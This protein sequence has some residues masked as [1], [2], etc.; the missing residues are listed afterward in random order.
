MMRRSTWNCD[1]GEDAAEG[2]EQAADLAADYQYV[3]EAQAVAAMAARAEGLDD[4]V[5]CVAGAYTRPLLSSTRAVSV[6]GNHSTHPKHPLTPPE[7]RLHKPYVLP[8]SH[9]KRSS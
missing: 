6:T 9:T 1:A 8:R 2:L 5:V 4:V 7:H 3:S